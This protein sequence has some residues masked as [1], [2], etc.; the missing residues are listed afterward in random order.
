MSDV[1]PIPQVR[2][3][4]GLQFPSQKKVLVSVSVFQ[5]QLYITKCEEQSLKTKQ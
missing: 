4:K 1:V 3:L 2:D 5:S